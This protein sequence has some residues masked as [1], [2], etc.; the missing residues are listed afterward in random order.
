MRKIRIHVIAL[1]CAA[2]FLLGGCGSGGDETTGDGGHSD[3][4]STASPEGELD[5]GEWQGVV[6]IGEETWKFGMTSACAVRD[7]AF[8]FVG[9]NADSS[10]RVAGGFTEDGTETTLQ[11]RV[12]DGPTWDLGGD[13]KFTMADHTLQG[14][15]D[16]IDE[17]NPG[18]TTPGEFEVTC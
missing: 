1:L 2:G 8:M 13:P 17:N 11:V 5:V 12:N 4:T 9:E 6:T 10:A 15:G 16:F 14:T 3:D 18:V 7:G